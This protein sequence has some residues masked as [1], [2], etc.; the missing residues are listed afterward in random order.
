MI[1]A[2]N[3]AL[4]STSNAQIIGRNGEMPLRDFLNRYLPYTLHA[5]TGHFVTPSGRLS[6]Q[7]DIMLL[8]PRY[9]LLSENADGSVLVMLHSVV[10]TIEVKTRLA[11]KDIR[12]MREDAIKINTLAGEVEGYA[13]NTE[14]WGMIE[15]WGFAYG[16]TNR[17]NT[18]EDKYTREGKPEE[19]GLDIC[20]LR[21]HPKDAMHVQPLG[22]P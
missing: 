16:C 1:A 14:G 12:K 15:P 4:A 22:L 20:L 9:P 21:S 13:Y 18:L 19:A 10:A 7:I 2:I 11:S 3:R 8:D 6:P 5:A 17:L